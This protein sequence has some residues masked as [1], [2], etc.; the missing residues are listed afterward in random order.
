MKEKEN[1]ERK[2]ELLLVLGHYNITKNIFEK[3]E[4]AANFFFVVFVKILY[5]LN[6]AL[7]VAQSL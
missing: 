5:S 4:V 2:G 3:S 1:R 7:F 6:V